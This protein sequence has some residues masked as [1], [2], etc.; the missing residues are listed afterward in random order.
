VSDRQH[1]TYAA[2]TSLPSDPVL[3]EFIPE[4]VTQWRKDFAT[5]FP[6][7]I[8]RRNA[9]D[10]YRFGHTIK[11]SFLQFGFTDLAQAGRDIMEDSR[12][13]DWSSPVQRVAALED[14]LT[15]IEARFSELT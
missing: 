11:G 7:I 10:L 4:F 1:I 15:A 6:D 3:R 5:M 13:G 2:P 12:N 8:Q 14:V 9:E